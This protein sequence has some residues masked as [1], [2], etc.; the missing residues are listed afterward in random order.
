[1]QRLQ[2][3]ITNRSID[4]IAN[5]FFTSDLALKDNVKF[6][7]ELWDYKSNVPEI[8]KKHNIAWARIAKY[9]LSFYNLRG[10]VLI[11]GINDNYE[12]HK[13]TSNVD[14]KKF[15][16]KLKKFI[17]DSI[18]VD[19]VN[20]NR[21]DNGKYIGIVIIPP[22]GSVLEKFKAD[23]PCDEQGNFLFKAGW[24]A[25]RKGDQSIILDIKEFENYKNQCCPAK[26]P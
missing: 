6:E 2:N 12:I 22:R 15:N 13:T 21:D 11:F 4:E 23:A 24:S 5:Y 8:G 9:V 16:D 10:G 19:F 20:Y 18:Y 17:P 26:Q 3:A 1:M 14:S 25:I 7:N